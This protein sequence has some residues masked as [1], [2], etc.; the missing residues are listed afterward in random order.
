[1]VMMAAAEFPGSAGAA[2]GGVNGQT[3]ATFLDALASGAPSPGGGSAAALA[4]ALAAALVAMVCR[5]TSQRDPG[6]EAL[7][8]IALTADGLRE[9]LQGLAGADA[10]AYQALL[11]ARRLPAH[12]RPA[13]A[14]AA[15]RRATEVPLD[16]VATSR[17]VL[18]LADRIA[19]AARASTVSDLSVAAVAARAAL[20]G[21][22]VTAGINL[23]DSTDRD[24][25][26]VAQRRLDALVDEGRAL[27]ER[28]S[29]VLA[30]RIGRAR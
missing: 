17:D 13:A 21:G 6:A 23:R 8:G 3:I 4:G 14:Q 26:G 19:P 10:D 2:G 25:V 16:V 11:T 12:A 7:A 24:F 18:T 9:R 15:L 27:A 28:V 29:A 30:E 20:D 5:V 1:M 22:A